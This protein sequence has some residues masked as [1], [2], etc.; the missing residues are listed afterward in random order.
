MLY[1]YLL[2]QTMYDKKRIL[3]FIV[4]PSKYYVFR[5]TI[6][7]LK[8]HGHDVNILITSKDVLEDLIKCEKWNYV[9]IFPEGRKIRGLPPLISSGINFFRTIY[10]LYKYAKNEQYDLFVTDDLLVF[11]TKFLK[12]PSFVFTDDDISVTKQFS[13]ILSRASHI[14]APGITNLGKYN[15]KKISFN[16]YKEL[17]YLSPNYFEPNIEVVKMINPTLEKYFVLRLVSLKAYH[18][19][20]KKGLSDDQVQKII[21]LLETKGKVFISAERDLPKQL[22]KYEL[23]I[24]SDKI[25]HILYYADLFIGD[26]QTMTSE[27]SILGTPAFRCNDFVGKISV[28]DE[29]EAK[30]GL[31]FNYSPNEFNDMYSKLQEVLSKKNFKEE[32]KQRREVLLSEKI[33]LSNFMIWLF[34][35]YP[36]S[37]SEYQ[38]NPYV[39]Y[40]FK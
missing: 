34:E 3:F 25:A 29:K 17:A 22:Q 2:L 31:S 33:D 37:V 26:S 19:V 28:M 23:K 5:Q 14:L 6:N 40:R 13:I 11:L 16:S 35:N 36:D 12:V 8:D 21:N 1:A 20:F 39:Q 7:T 18:D 9:N 10:R 27:A 15:D 24:Q 4:H 38:I 30:Y 32:F